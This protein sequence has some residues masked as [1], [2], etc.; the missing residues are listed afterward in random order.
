MNVSTSS[1]VA[2]MRRMNTLEKYKLLIFTVL[3]LVVI[4]AIL[5]VLNVYNK[6]K[7]LHCPISPDP[8]D[9]CLDRTYT[10]H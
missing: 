4:A 7:H 8:N 2:I 3:L 9:V 5:L 10:T 1:I 6:P